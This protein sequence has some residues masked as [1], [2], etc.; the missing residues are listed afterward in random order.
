MNT[1]QLEALI[2]IERN[3]IKSMRK[4]EQEVISAIIFSRGDLRK[5]YRHKVIEIQNNINNSIL[6][7]LDLCDKK[8]TPSE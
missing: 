1:Y 8:E 2:N 5:T 7:I 3:L 6:T 4:Q